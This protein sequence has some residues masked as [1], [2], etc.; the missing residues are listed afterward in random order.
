MLAWIRGPG[1][2][3]SLSVF[4]ATLSWVGL[5]L[6][7][8]ASDVQRCRYRIAWNGIP[9]ASA[10]IEIGSDYFGGQRAYVIATRAVTN[11]FVDLFWRF[12][13]DARATV[14]AG[15]L[16][17]LSF[18][19]DRRANDTPE[20]TWIDFDDRAGRARSVYIKRDRRKELDA[21]ASMVVDPITAAFRALS[22]DIR[23]GDALRYE[24]FTGESRYQ[25]VF[26][27]VGEDRIVVPAG[28]FEAL[29]VEPE[30]FKLGIER[31]PDHRLHRAS[32]WVTRTPLRTIL[33][34]RSQVLIGSVTLDLVQQQIAPSS[35][36][37]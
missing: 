13:G 22:S 12:R 25:A 37:P 14:L 2:Q 29:R 5:A 6:A 26:H 24:I 7:A 27:A 32:I 18:S 9:A 33:R 21:D 30:I 34:I 11:P 16:Q 31:R 35:G 20:A 36:Q 28:E 17:P 8:P 3:C 10:T 1:V 23:V 15:D 19:F 4:L